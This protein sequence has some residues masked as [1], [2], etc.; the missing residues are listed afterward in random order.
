ME[1]VST[2][3]RR[4]RKLFALTTD[5][6]S[7]RLTAAKA[8]TE[9]EIYSR[10]LQ[11]RQRAFMY[12]EYESPGIRTFIVHI[13]VTPRRNPAS[14]QRTFDAKWERKSSHGMGST[15]PNVRGPMTFG[16]RRKRCSCD[17]HG[18]VRIASF[19]KSLPALKI[20]VGGGARSSRGA[21][22]G[23]SALVVVTYEGHPS[24]LPHR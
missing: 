19:K 14:R 18:H 11:V 10:C 5:T 1:Y 6:S 22:E 23:V 24:L 12:H 9:R 4:L 8:S 7:T 3:I 21:L 13:H 2:C 20:A 15:R 16:D 17:L